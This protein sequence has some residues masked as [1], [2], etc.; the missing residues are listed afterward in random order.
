MSLSLDGRKNCFPGGSGYGASL[1]GNR[2]S[3]RCFVLRIA[4]AHRDVTKGPETSRPVQC[5]GLLCLFQL[6]PGFQASQLALNCAL[7]CSRVAARTPP[8]SQ[9][10]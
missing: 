10:V 2:A 6:R 1:L 8:K 4:P 7:A 5:G 3:M 9:S